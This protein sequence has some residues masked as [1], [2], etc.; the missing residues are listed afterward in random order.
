MKVLEWTIDKWLMQG[1]LTSILTGVG[2]LVISFTIEY[3]KRFRKGRQAR[4]Q[5]IFL[6]RILCGEPVLEW[7]NGTVC[8]RNRKEPLLG[9]RHSVPRGHMLFE[10]Y[11]RAG[12]FLGVGQGYYSWVN[13]TRR[14]LAVEDKSMAAVISRV[15]WGGGPASHAQG[16]ASSTSVDDEIT[17]LEWDTGK[18]IVATVHD[19]L[20]PTNVSAISD[21][22]V[23][24]YS[25]SN[26]N[27][28]VAKQEIRLWSTH[29]AEK[30]REKGVKLDVEGEDMLARA[31]REHAYLAPYLRQDVLEAAQNMEREKANIKKGRKISCSG[32]KEKVAVISDESP[33][34]KLN[35]KRNESK[36]KHGPSSEKSE[37][38]NR[39]IAQE[40]KASLFMVERKPISLEGKPTKV[41][42]DKQLT[43]RTSPQKREAAFFFNP[44]IEARHTFRRALLRRES[45]DMKTRTKLSPLVRGSSIGA[46]VTRSDISAR[47]AHSQV[48]QN[49]SCA[50]LR[51]LPCM[52]ISAVKSSSTANNTVVGVS[53]RKSKTQATGLRG[54]C[55]LSKKEKAKSTPKRAKSPKVKKQIENQKAADSEMETKKLPLE[56]KSTPI[57]FAQNMTDCEM[58]NVEPNFVPYQENVEQSYISPKYSET[59]SPNQGTKIS[60]FDEDENKDAVSSSI[61]GYIRTLVFGD[62][63]VQRGDSS[64]VS[65]PRNVLLMPNSPMTT[66]AEAPYGSCA[67][68]SSSGTYQNILEN[69]KLPQTNENTLLLNHGTAEREM[70]ARNKEDVSMVTDQSTSDFL[71][72]SRDVVDNAVSKPTRSSSEKR[73]IPEK[74][75]KSPVRPNIKSKR[76]KKRSRSNSFDSAVTREKRAGS[77]KSL[78]NLPPPTS[79]KIKNTKQLNRSQKVESD[80]SSTCPVRRAPKNA[81]RKPFS[82]RSLLRKESSDGSEF[83]TKLGHGEKSGDVETHKKRAGRSIDNIKK[84]K[85]SALQTVDKLNHQENSH[86]KRKEKILSDS[87]STVDDFNFLHI[88]KVFKDK[89]GKETGRRVNKELKSE[90]ILSPKNLKENTK[91]DL[92][93]K[94]T[95]ASQKQN[96][97]SSKLK[98]RNDSLHPGLNVNIARKK[99]KDVSTVSK[100][101]SNH[102]GISDTKEVYRISKKLKEKKK[103]QQAASKMLDNYNIEIKK[104]EVLGSVVSLVTYH[105]KKPTGAPSK[106]FQDLNLFVVD[107]SKNCIDDLKR[108]GDSPQVQRIGDQ[109]Y[110]ANTLVGDFESNHSILQSPEDKSEV[111]YPSIEFDTDSESELTYTSKYGRYSL[112]LH[113]PDGPKKKTCTTEEEITSVGRSFLLRP[114]ALDDVVKNMETQAKQQRFEE[115]GQS[116]HRKSEDVGCSSLLPSL[117]GLKKNISSPD[118]LLATDSAEFGSRTIKS[119]TT[120]N[121]SETRNVGV[122]QSLKPTDSQ[123]FQV[124]LS[125]EEAL[126]LQTKGHSPDKALSS[127]NQKMLVNSSSISNE[128]F[129][130]GFSNTEG[131]IMLDTTFLFLENETSGE[132]MVDAKE[133]TSPLESYDINCVS[134]K[135]NA[136]TEKIFPESDQTQCLDS[137]KTDDENQCAGISYQPNISE[138]KKES[139]KVIGNI[140]MVESEA[141]SSGLNVFE[142]TAKTH[143]EKNIESEAIERNVRSEK[144]LQNF[145]SEESEKEKSSSSV[146]HVNRNKSPRKSRRQ[147]L[148]KSAYM[149]EKSK[150]KSNSGH[151]NN[152]TPSKEESKKKNFGSKDRK[153]PQI[154]QKHSCFSEERN[155]KMHAT[156]S[157]HS[158]NKGK[159]RNFFKK[160]VLQKPFQGYT[161]TIANLKELSE[162]AIKK[163]LVHQ[164]LCVNRTSP[165]KIHELVR[166]KIQED[167]P[168]VGAQDNFF[169][170]SDSSTAEPLEASSDTVKSRELSLTSNEIVIEPKKREAYEKNH[171]HTGQINLHDIKYQSPQVRPEAAKLIKALDGTATPLKARDTKATE[172]RS[173]KPSFSHSP[174]NGSK[175]KAAHIFGSN[176]SFSVDSFRTACP[177]STVAP[178]EP[179]VKVSNYRLAGDHFRTYRQR[180][181]SDEEC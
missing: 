48:K 40:V 55:R 141:M 24:E 81:T 94:N 78:S 122:H 101:S 51:S 152:E 96:R 159:L 86:P 128:V 161:E 95:K 14:K 179:A 151:P 177:P 67:I 100:L 49:V 6:Q 10:Q 60:R 137:L 69:P 107:Q 71:S 134:I 18:S 28:A 167:I 157:A 25:G 21:Q 43:K 144:G 42:T 136:S 34:K 145:V 32:S 3:I 120:S 26:S 4:E 59:T 88:M 58:S 45:S 156:S 116:P 54:K 131:K 140:K 1:L 19:Y 164:R 90:R 124:D 93:H 118:Y 47:R 33:S 108:K 46:K 75:K 22:G 127:T 117:K 162:N 27:N 154:T 135:P 168:V 61:S 138:V 87:Q 65:G 44:N 8:A 171:D 62:P 175:Q 111:P 63:L 147:T 12:N 160:P 172:N 142:V 180:K 153:S 9:T 76:K 68:S 92:S 115:N 2:F 84:E 119:I 143:C 104:E 74:A 98:V 149:K 150:V 41:K 170:K 146:V 35:K 169:P 72:C 64:Q 73:S 5:E 82:K 91:S 23:K 129:Y 30:S 80:T 106:G 176:A 148:D 11:K 99:D 13:E 85:L 163:S 123:T 57:L 110:R 165:V 50:S 29:T 174:V 155:D 89:K 77:I 103:R 102:S 53:P 39:E 37:H 112:C 178:V 133:I 7:S 36:L 126:T 125:G 97:H 109:Q 181:E 20:S 113:D 56:Q 121:E 16:G 31:L 173:S 52:Q 79:P 166:R 15:S 83:I 158:P 114:S 70:I 66:I 17:S 130:S 139:P 105:P 132:G 38:Q